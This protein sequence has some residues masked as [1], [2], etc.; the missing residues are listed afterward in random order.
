MVASAQCHSSDC[1][2][3]S[4]AVIII[5]C[6]RGRTDFVLCVTVIFISFMCALSGDSF[7][8]LKEGVLERVLVCWCG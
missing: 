3:R 1:K 5:E 4:P 8:L 6:H 7:A 2:V